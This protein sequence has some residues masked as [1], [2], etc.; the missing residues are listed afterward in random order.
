[1]NA[2]DYDIEYLES[3]RLGERLE[4]QTWLEL[5]PRGTRSLCA[6]NR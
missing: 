1:M 6:Y 3:A 4:F 2:L 5:A